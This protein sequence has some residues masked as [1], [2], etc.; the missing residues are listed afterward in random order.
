VAP[1]ASSKATDPSASLR[2]TEPRVAILLST[3]NGAAFLR[4]QLD[5][6]LSQTH[7]NW[8]LYWRD[9]GSR[10]ATLE[11]MR[12][13]IATA[14]QGRCV[15][16]VQPASHLGVT[17]SFLAMLAAVAPTLAEA[18]TVAFADQ[19][20]VWLPQ[21]LARGLAALDRMRPELPALYCARQLLVDAKLAP[22]GTSRGGPAAGGFPASLAQNVATGCT[23]MLNCAAA[24]LVAASRP[25]PA[26]LHDWWCYLMVTAAGGAML[27]DNEPV[28]LYRQHAGN[29][30]GSPG[31]LWRR[32]AAAVRR[33]PGVFMAVLRQ[34]V[35]A[36]LAHPELLTEDARG[37]LLA[38]DAA[39]RGGWRRRLAALR[40]AGFTRQ[41]WPETIVFRTWFLLG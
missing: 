6:L 32:G 18:D 10:D 41:T 17:R 26:T 38:I 31:S 35:A 36:L 14:G 23:V 39:L 5:S 29:V 21:K 19:D 8:V 33:G 1:R 34:H 40:R 37:D 4:E 28:V 30:I 22:L 7:D 13:F 27:Q 20:D 16:I 15:Q 11:V 12:G 9:D 25:A 3:F 24:R 2:R